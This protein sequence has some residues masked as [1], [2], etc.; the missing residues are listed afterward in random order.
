VLLVPTQ[1][2]FLRL[3]LKRAI[4]NSAAAI[5]LL[6]V[7]AAVYKTATLPQHGIAPMEAVKIAAVVIPGAIIGSFLGGKGVHKLPGKVVRVV[8]IV[9]MALAC[10]KLL[11]VAPGV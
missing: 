1:Q 3:P 11:T 10:Y 4:S 8:F 9:L 7:V 2:V 5:A 6:T